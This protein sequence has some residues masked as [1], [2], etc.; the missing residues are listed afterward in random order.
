M[1][2]DVKMGWKTNKAN[3]NNKNKV[4]RRSIKQERPGGNWK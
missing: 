3:R 1:V 4:P 2:G